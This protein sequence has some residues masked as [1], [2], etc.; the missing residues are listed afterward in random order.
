MG[1]QPRITSLAVFPAALLA[2]ILASAVACYSP[3]QYSEQADAEVLP[4][5][6]ETQAAVLGDREER[7]EFPE[8]LSEEEPP[9][10]D[11]LAPEEEPPEAEHLDLQASLARAFTSSREF[12]NER[13][14]LYLQGLGLSLTRYDFGPI[15]D[16]TIAGIWQDAEDEQS[17][18]SLGGLLGV[19][20]I[21]P[22]GGTVGLVG[23]LGSAVIG[24]QAFPGV[25]DPEY[26]SNALLTLNQPLMRGFGYEVSHEQL[27]QGER[28]LVYAVRDF[29]LFREDFSISIADDYFSLVS[30]RQQ[31]TVLR[32]TYADSVFD[33]HKAEAMRQVD[34]NKDEDVFLARRRLIE[35]EN[36]L[37]T[38]EVD[39]LEEV[40]RFKL[41]LGLQT[42]VPVVIDEKDPPYEPVS[43]DAD[44]AVEVALHNRLDLRTAAERLED[45]ERRVR[46]AADGLRPQLDFGLIGGLDGSDGDLSGAA[47][48]EWNS[49]AA[50]TLGLP[51]NRQAERNAYR[52]AQIALDQA[53]RDYDQLLDDTDRDVRNQLRQLRTIE[54]QVELQREQITQEQRAV[55]VIEIRY[56]A[57]DVDNRDL[58]DARASLARARNELIRL[59]AEHLTER[60]R[61][62]RTMGVLVIGS[63]GSWTS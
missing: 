55:A 23:T 7:M 35:T 16:A 18:T 42:E 13:E 22:A 51:V 8:V 43:L 11:P 38:E 40:D 63:D 3:E 20:Q 4:M 12:L 24:G 29:E 34:R 31:L 48:D 30:R 25:D 32:Q 2:P 27:T 59:L 15:L 17:R 6:E 53:R 57:G 54:Q 61:L 28:D 56:Q 46:I 41:R 47:P 21:M 58:L 44:S 26:N 1:R 10:P 52:S 50:L 45:D 5:V 9:P 33:V 62:M 60:L 14:N 19:S 39:Y 36:L 37:I 49:T